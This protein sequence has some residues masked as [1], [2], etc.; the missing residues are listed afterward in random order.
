MNYVMSR[1]FIVKSMCNWETSSVLYKN[2]E[3]YMALFHIRIFLCLHY[4]CIILHYF[5]MWHKCMGHMY[6][7]MTSGMISRSSRST[8]VTHPGSN[9]HFG[10][11]IFEVIKIISYIKI[12]CF[13]SKDSQ[14]LE[15]LWFTIDYTQCISFL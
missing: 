2:E 9:T 5:S 15:L 7:T 14:N 10:M 12:A 6:V 4:N 3:I 13:Y 1:D 8:S 11:R